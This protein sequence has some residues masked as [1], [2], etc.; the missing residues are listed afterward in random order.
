[1]DYLAVKWECI[2][3]VCGFCEFVL[4]YFAL[5]YHEPCVYE[6]K[7]DNDNIVELQMKLNVALQTERE[8]S[9]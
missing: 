4:L 3:Y 9:D 5:L 1:M 2:L 6:H 7:Y 8:K